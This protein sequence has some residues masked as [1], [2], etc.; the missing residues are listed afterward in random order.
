MPPFL[1]MRWKIGK[2]DGNEERDCARERGVKKF[3][4]WQAD[5]SVENERYDNRLRL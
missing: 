4:G 1:R 3:A 5:V 2:R